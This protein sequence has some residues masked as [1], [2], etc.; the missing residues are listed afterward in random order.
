MAEDGTMTCRWVMPYQK[1]GK[2]SV[3]NLG[4]EPVDVRLQVKTGAWSW[5]DRSM[6]F[7]A[8]RRGQYPVPT[9][10]H[11]DWNYITIKG[12]G[13][14]VDDTLTVI[15]PVAR[16]WGKGDEKIWIDEESFPSLFGTGTEDYYGY[17]WGGVSTDFYKH[18]FHAQPRAHVYN[19]L[20]RKRN[21]GERD[22]RGFSVETRT[23]SLDTIPFAK[24][25]QFDME[26]WSGSDCHMGYAV[27]T[28]WY[29]FAETTSNRRPE[30]LE[31]RNVPPLPDMRK[32]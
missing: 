19:K 11:L 17:S 10:P 12:R 2:I 29:G 1:S 15:N 6:Y 13:V 18:P 7:H 5:D 30:P 16:W 4:D 31:V 14:Y 25:L 3:L 26:V 27:A 8:N 20:N 28:Y 23:R 22:T 32:E 24:S 9:R 21:T